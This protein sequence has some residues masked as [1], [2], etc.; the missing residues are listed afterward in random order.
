M[1]SCQGD[2]VG[3]F[4]TFSSPSCPVNT[5]IAQ[6]V[7]QGANCQQPMQVVADCARSTSATVSSGSSGLP[8]GAIIG[9]AVAGVI[10]LV[11]L[12]LLAIWCVLRRKRWQE[13][14]NMVMQGQ[15]G[16]IEMNPY[17]NP[18][19]AFG[20]GSGPPTPQSTAPVLKERPDIEVDAK[21]PALEESP[22]SE[23]DAEILNSM[24]IAEEPVVSQQAPSVN[25]VQYHP[26]AFSADQM[27]P[28]IFS[29][30]SDGLEDGGDPL[31]Y[32]TQFKRTETPVERESNLE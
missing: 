19:P 3:Q 26:E 21:S 10:I 6:S 31:R 16:G 30:G 18:S 27:E 11:L 12:I 32:T 13:N 15:M 1:L 20:R 29:F 2:Q 23:V 7:V 5:G 17:G 14:K 28:E 24:P 8:L 25:I 4:Q 22:D 9:I